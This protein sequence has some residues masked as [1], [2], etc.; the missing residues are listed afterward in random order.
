[1][2]AN[3][4]YSHL[5]FALVLLNNL[6]I[7]ISWVFHYCLI[8]FIFIRQSTTHRT[9]CWFK[10]IV[11][12]TLYIMHSV[13]EYIMS[14][15]SQNVKSVSESMNCEHVQTDRQHKLCNFMSFIYVI[16]SHDDPFTLC[17]AIPRKFVYYACYTRWI[18]C[19]ENVYYFTNNDVMTMV[20]QQNSGIRNISR[21][22]W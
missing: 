7:G 1:M 20:L 22:Q 4:Q 15:F 21:I 8:V 3:Y 13:H 10:M 9:Q 12:I 11:G 16:R 18:T 2:I 17:F 6:I 14:L 19:W 5:F